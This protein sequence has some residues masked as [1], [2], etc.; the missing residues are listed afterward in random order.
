[1]METEA[2]GTVIERLN[3]VEDRLLKV[4]PPS[5]LGVIMMKM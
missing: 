1:M 5:D 2:K 3:L 4:S